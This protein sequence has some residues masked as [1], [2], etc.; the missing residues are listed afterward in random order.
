MQIGIV[1]EGPSDIAVLRNVLKGALGLERRDVIAIRP[2]LSEDETDR[3]ARRARGYQPPTLESFSNW[4]DVL[5]ECTARERIATFLSAPLAEERLVVVHLDTAECE[6]PGYDIVRPSRDDPDY[7]SVLR[8]RVVSRLFVLLSDELATNVRFAIAVEE[9]DAWVLAAL[10]EADTHRTLN[11]KKRL[12]RHQQ[13]SAVRGEEPGRRYRR[14]S[15]ALGNRKGLAKAS[16]RNGSL[17]LFVASL[18]VAS[19]PATS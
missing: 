17:Q 3:S 13:Y 14:L 16:S 15:Q 8:A 19:D 10:G 2:E 5:K 6:V 4:L 9:T 18:P 7:V 12:E 11:S 1:A